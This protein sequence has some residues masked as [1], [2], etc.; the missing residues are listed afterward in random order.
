MNRTRIAHLG[1]GPTYRPICLTHAH[2]RVECTCS[3][4][5]FIRKTFFS[6]R[7]TATAQASLRIRAILPEPMLFLEI[8][9]DKETCYWPFQMTAHMMN[10]ILDNPYLRPFSHWSAVLYTSNKITVL[11]FP[12]FPSPA[13]KQ[14][15]SLATSFPLNIRRISSDSQL[16]HLQ[17][18]L[19]CVFFFCCFLCHVYLYLFLVYFY[20]YLCISLNVFIYL[21]ICNEHEHR[22]PSTRRTFFVRSAAEDSGHPPYLELESY[23][24]PHHVF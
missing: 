11:A 1:L 15:F 19:C 17:P 20:Y 14:C 4:S 22:K 13:I 7:R 3:Q 16:S 6:Y 9:P 5:L 8:I 23:Q 10:H 24:S 21:F 12:R 2:T 18:F